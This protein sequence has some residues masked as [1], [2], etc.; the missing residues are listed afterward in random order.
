MTLNQ[1]GGFFEPEKPL[2]LDIREEIVDL[3]NSGY[4]MKKV[5]RGALVTR[6]CVSKPFTAKQNSNL[7]N[8][9]ETQKLGQG[10]GPER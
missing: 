1:L 5:S 3:H 2:P 9:E 6:R 4:S 10:V 7:K 8:I